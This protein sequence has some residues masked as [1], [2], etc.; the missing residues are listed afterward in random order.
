M[1]LPWRAD[2]RGSAFVKTA[3]DVDELTRGD[4]NMEI[5]ESDSCTVI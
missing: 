4:N 3:I 1:D 5:G 2:L